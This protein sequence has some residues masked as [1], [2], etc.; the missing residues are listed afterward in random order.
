MRLNF[1][2]YNKHEKNIIE[3]ISIKNKKNENIHSNHY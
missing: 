2:E 3:Q 1:M